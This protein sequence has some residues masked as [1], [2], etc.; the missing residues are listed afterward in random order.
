MASGPDRLTSADGR[1]LLAF[2]AD[3]ISELPAAPVEPLVSALNA[4]LGLYDGLL[5]YRDHESLDVRDA[6]F[7]DG[8]GLTLRHAAV[9]WSEHPDFQEHWAPPRVP[10]E[11]L[12]VYD[13]RYRATTLAR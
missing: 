7:I 1:A 8:I 9:R 10:V 4:Q 12:L 2:V 3:R 5:R 11:G 6:G 13:P